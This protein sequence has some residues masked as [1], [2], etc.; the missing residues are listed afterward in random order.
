M[1]TLLNDNFSKK[2]SFQFLCLFLVS[3]GTILTFFFQNY[4]NNLNLS[5]F[6]QIPLFTALFI[7]LSLCGSLSKRAKTCY[8]IGIL[9]ILWFWILQ[10]IHYL[11]DGSMNQYGN[12]IGAYLL[13]LPFASVMEDGKQQRGLKFAATVA[14]AL[15]LALFLCTLLLMAG[16][17]PEF[18]SDICFFDGPRLR[19]FLHPNSCANL[20]LIGI[21]S[22]LYLCFTVKKKFEKFL[23]LLFAALFF[24]PLSMTNCRSV[25][26]LCA[27]LVGSTIQIWLLP[28]QKTKPLLRLI[29]T[30]LILAASIF[31][32]WKLS[33]ILYEI[34]DHGVPSSET[35]HS[36]SSD[37][38]TLNNRTYI[39]LC[40]IKSLF[41]KPYLFLIGTDQSGFHITPFLGGT[42]TSAHNSWLE[43]LM[44][45]G[46]PGFAIA[47][48]L[49]FIALRSCIRVLFSRHV[50]VS[51]GTKTIAILCLMLMVHG[52]ME[53]FLFTG[54][55]DPINFFF[56]LVLGYLWEASV[57]SS[58]DHAKDTNS[59]EPDKFSAHPLTEEQ[60]KKL[61]LTDYYRPYRLSGKAKKTSYQ[62]IKR[63]FDFLFSAV[64]FLILLPLLLILMLLIFVDDP[65]AGPI[66]CQTR[67]GKNGKPFTLYK[68]RSMHPNADS[69]RQE[70]KACNEA[71]DKAFKIK[72]DPRITHV[73]YFIRRYMLDE[74]PQFI[75]VM[76]GQMSL[77]GPRP[78]LP[79]EVEAYDA[80]DKQ[81][82]SITP[83][84]TCIWQ[85]Y[86][87]RHE[88]SFQDWVAMDLQYIENRSLKMD[89]L[90]ICKTIKTIFSG[91][92]V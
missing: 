58:S 41:A 64:V 81:R 30:L 67:I 80:Y 3:V 45:S 61:G 85:T 89:F 40:A 31:V 53:P 54:R 4:L 87:H 75:N 60:K 65:T 14:I 91:N 71:Q 38:F 43:I 77:V 57:G 22:C 66:Y 56:L 5:Y 13:A 1:N 8:A 79:D 28:Y 74:L 36:M 19:L 49:T 72:A 51:M 83:G 32:L 11:I 33:R 21:G 70:L 50:T 46:I 24:V 16:K 12:F 47:L 7:G 25:I 62:I 76:L 86:P 44:Y 59:P 29:T 10:P 27:V 82:L 35:Q 17:M 6:L 55:A 92:G 42:A 90:L 34:N 20:L 39:F 84:L 78:P 52:F 48:I 15:S 2:R 18:I 88:I 73:G 69:I 37:M 9:F 63:C 26:L 23:F 68:L